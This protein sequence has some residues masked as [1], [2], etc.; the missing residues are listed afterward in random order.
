MEI[1]HAAAQQACENVSISPWK[2]KIQ[3]YQQDI[4]SFCTQT[5]ERFDLI[6]ANPPY[7]QTGVDCRNEERNT[8]RYF[9]AQSHLHWLETAAA[10]LAP[11]GKISFVLPFDAGETLLK[12]TALY[13]V[14]RCDVITKQG[15]APQRMLLTFATQPQTLRYDELIIYDT[16]NQYHADFVALT[17][18]FYLNF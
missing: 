8:A 13:C 7:F 9:A 4:D 18:D 10:C 6:V 5:A 16:Q 1:D 14:V 3:V 12:S 11:K 17:Q 2:N 15:K